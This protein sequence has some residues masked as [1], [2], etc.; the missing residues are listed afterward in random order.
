MI[1]KTIRKLDPEF[2]PQVI[3]AWISQVTKFAV[4]GIINTG[5][6][7][8]IYFLLTRYVNFFGD[9]VYLTKALSYSVGVVTSYTLNRAWTFKSKFSPVHSFLPFL[10]VNLISIALNAVLMGVFVDFLFLSELVAL[11]LVTGITFVWNF[12]A[13]KILVFRS[14]E[15]TRDSESNANAHLEVE[16]GESPV[17][18]P[19][20]LS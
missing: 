4:V 2:Q 20:L 7:L 18:K 10:G 16:V 13:S 5:I 15:N 11:S 19:R 17:W 1:S 12:L 3:S 6:D 14:L 9:Y 8:G